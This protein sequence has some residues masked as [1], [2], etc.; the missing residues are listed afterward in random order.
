M[1]QLRVLNCQL[2]IGSTAIFIVTLALGILAAPLPSDGQQPAKVYR[3][4]YLGFNPDTTDRTPQDCPREPGPLQQAFREGLRE[5]GYI[6]GQNLVIECRWTEGREE[7]APALAAELVSLKLDLI[8]AMGTLQ[9]LAAKQATS[10]IPI[11]MVGVV[12]PVGRGLVASLAHPGGNVTGLTDMLIEMEGKRLQLLK[13]AVPKASRVAVLSYLTGAPRSG[14]RKEEEAAARAL[15]VTLQFHEVRGLE[16]FPNAFTAM[17]KARAEALLV[18]PDPF[19]HEHAQRIVELAAQ[20]RLPAIYPYRG[21]AQAGG[22]LAYDVNRPDIFRRLGFYVDKILKGAKPADLPVEQPT[23][24]ELIINL[25]TAK[26]LGLTIPQSLLIRA[27]E[28]IQ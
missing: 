8:V 17:T 27:D 16:E 26:A 4:G 15:G 25:K 3:I 12:N 5:H 21:A 2:R 11:V 7:R 19:F 6:E 24:F 14:F 13:E 20:S 9:V 10:T 22:L 1:R 18:V 28:V 23:K